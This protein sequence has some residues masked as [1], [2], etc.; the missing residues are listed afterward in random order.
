MEIYGICSN[1]LK[2]HIQPMPLVNAKQGERFEIKAFTGGATAHMRL[3]SMGLRIGDKIDVINN[4]DKGQ[5]VIA[6]AH[7]RYV[8]GRGLAKKILIEPVR[9]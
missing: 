9:S 3:L 5:L 2:D 7:Q 6:V 4:L 1:C 8:L